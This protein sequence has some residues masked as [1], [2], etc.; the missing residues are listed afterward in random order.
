[1]TNRAIIATRAYDG[2]VGGVKFTTSGNP[3]LGRATVD[4]TTR[5]GKT[6]LAFA[7]RQGWSISGST[8]TVPAMGEGGHPQD[9]SEAELEGYLTAQHVQ[10][11]STASKADLL[12]AV[13]A[14][15][16][17][18]AGGGPATPGEVAGHTQGT[19]PPEGAPVVPGDD[20]AEAAL[21]RT[22]LSG[23]TANAIAPTV[24]TQ[25]A[26]ASAVAGETETFT[27][28][29]AGTPT[30]GV[31]WERQTKGAGA[32]RSISGADDLTYTTPALTVAANAG[33]K[34]RAVVS[35]SAGSVT[36]NAATLTVTAS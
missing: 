6:V 26:N 17:D 34:Y 24:T 35:S 31:Q 25:P 15:F 33:D 30:P 12:A 23:N 1:M 20:A 27:V 21:W 28:A 13:L 3:P 9:W 2:T 7:K 14:A 29:V 4:D 36:T 19:I 11:P 18:K 8:P 22:P 10:F 5:Q 32:W 16:A